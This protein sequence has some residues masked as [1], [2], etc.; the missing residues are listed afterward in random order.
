ML[1]A[2]LIT[3]PYIKCWTSNEHFGAG[4]K[5]YT[6]KANTT[7]PVNTWSDRLLTALNTNPIVLDSVG[8]AI[9]YV[10]QPIKLV[11]TTPTGGAIWTRDYLGEIATQPW[12]GAAIG[13]GANNYTVTTVPAIL[14]LN[15]RTMLIA[16]PDQDSLSTIV[17]TTPTVTGINDLTASGPYVGSTVSTFTVQIDSVSSALKLLLHAD[18]SA[19]TFV[20]SSVTARA[21]TANGDVTQ[22]ATWS[23]FGGKSASFDGTGDYL[24]CLDS[25]DWFLSTGNFTIETWIYPTV[26]TNMGLIGQYEDANNH[27]YWDFDGT[28]V[29]FYYKDASTVRASYAYTWTP[30]INTAYH[31]R[32]VRSGSNL[33]LYVDGTK[34]TWT[35]TTTAISTNALGNITGVLTIGYT[36]GSTYLT[37]GYMDEIAFHKGAALSTGATFTLATTAYTASDADTFMWKKDGGAWT[38]LVPITALLQ[39]LV[40]GLG[41]TY[42]IKTGHT[43]DDLWAI[44]VTTPVRVNLDGTGS[45]LVYKNANGVLEA[46]GA[47]DLKKDYPATLVYS[48]AQD[49]WFLNTPAAPATGTSFVSA[50]RYR[51]ILTGDYTLLFADQGYE[52]SFQGSHTLTLSAAADF[53]HRFTYIYS[54]DGVTTITADGSELIYHGSVSASSVILAANADNSFQLH[55]NGVTWH[56]L[57]TATQMF[58]G[59]ILAWGGTAA[60]TGHLLCQGAAI[61]RTTY[62]VLYAIIGTTFGAGDGST[63]FNVPDLRQRF[64]IGKA[65]SGTGSTLGGTGGNIDHAHSVAA[66]LLQTGGNGADFS[67][68]AASSVY[69]PSF[70]TTSGTTNPP[71]QTVNFIIKY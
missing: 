1:T 10:D 3:Y 32:L 13:D 23:K 63:T 8:E 11:F 46:L 45:K 9:I 66:T 54:E 37:T 71:F 21:V 68:G 29:R 52:L 15:D 2:P 19:A 16:T 14:S 39:V 65:A 26:V 59:T 43:I 35:T 70:T 7:T 5:L 69:M 55:S 28:S 34:V 44:A 31:L 67:L 36:Q 58:A 17:S 57:T 60:P 4:Y 33:Y 56:I 51:K 64:P 22:S 48:A 24:S 61:S 12:E 6:Y 41:V 50:I 18:G 38:T 25:D 53:A 42:A 62:S 49:A 27:W 40:E 30:S 20:D 47:G